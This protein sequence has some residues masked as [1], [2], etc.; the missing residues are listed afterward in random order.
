[1]WKKVEMQTVI[2]VF[3]CITNDLINFMKKVF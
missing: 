2:N 1:M 3:N